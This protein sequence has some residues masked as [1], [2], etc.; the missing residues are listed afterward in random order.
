MQVQ[1]T[2]RELGEMIGTARE[3]VN[4]LLHSWQNAGIVALRRGAIA[5]RKPDALKRL[6]EGE[7]EGD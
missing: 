5:I 4:K 7:A 2:Q 3:S 1:L 6:A